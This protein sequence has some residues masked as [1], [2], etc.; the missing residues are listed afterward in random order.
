M[1]EVQS[2]YQGRKGEENDAATEPTNAAKVLTLNFN[3]FMKPVSK[4]R[5]RSRSPKRSL[6]P[7]SQKLSLK[8]PET[9]LAD[10]KAAT[11]S[12]HNI[13]NAD[14]ALPNMSV[15]PPNLLPGYQKTEAEL[16]YERKVAAFISKTNMPEDKPDNLDKKIEKHLETKSSGS[17]TTRKR[18]TFTDYPV[19]DHDKQ[20]QPS[21]ELYSLFFQVLELVRFT[22]MWLCLSR[23]QPRYQG[24]NQGQTQRSRPRASY[25]LI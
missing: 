19:Y 3:E 2:F 7:F 16:E 21:N 9:L 13:A 6:S 1:R 24:E 8:N 17:T 15:P 23:Y 11:S 18:R 25:C 12:Q 5:S 4:V 14:I 22:S 10:P 20:Q